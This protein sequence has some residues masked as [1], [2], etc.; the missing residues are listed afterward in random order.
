VTL[1]P[2]HIVGSIE[3]TQ[4]CRGWIISS[5]AQI[6]YLLGNLINLSLDMKEYQAI[7][8]RLPFNT[9]RRIRRVRR[10]LDVDGY[11]SNFSN[12]L[13][14][15]LDAFEVQNDLRNLLAHGFMTVLYDPQGGIQFEFRKWHW[16]ESG[17]ETELIHRCFQVHLE[18]EAH[19]LKALASE[20]SE[21]FREI[22]QG[23][24]LIG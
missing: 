21:L 12:R 4:Q 11:F 18:Y 3:Q 20:A 16:T 13:T 19:Q 22:H 5:Y 10:I 9:A 7:E 2:K 24:G 14:E 6:E 23:L 8:G 15:I 1:P 17:E